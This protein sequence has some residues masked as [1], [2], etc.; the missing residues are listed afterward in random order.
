MHPLSPSP[1]NLKGTWVGSTCWSQRAFQRGRRQLGLHWG[2]RCWQQ[3][4]WGAR[5]TMKTLVQANTTLHHSSTLLELKAFP[6][7][8]RPAPITAW[9]RAWQPTRP[10]ASPTYH[11]IYSNHPCHNRKAH[12]AHIRGSPRAYSSGE[13]K[14][15][16]LGPTGCLLHKDT[17]PRLGNVSNLPSYINIDTEN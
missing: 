11:C 16:L 9:G 8:S 2:Q 17:S 5:Y 6:P 13:Q 15:I 1:E 14:N 4:S 3:P 10:Q 7:A 12:G